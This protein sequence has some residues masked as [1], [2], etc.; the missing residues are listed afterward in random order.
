LIQT[1][2]GVTQKIYLEQAT[3]LPTGIMFIKRVR[4]HF[5]AAGEPLYVESLAP[6]SSK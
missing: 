6:A 2:Q 5:D 3:Q 4:V 1:S